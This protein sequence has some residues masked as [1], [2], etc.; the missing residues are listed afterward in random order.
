MTRTATSINDLPPELLRAIVHRAAEH[1]MTK[2]SFVTRL[3]TL[4]A[5]SLVNRTIH[6][7]TQPLLATI[8]HVG[9]TRDRRIFVDKTLGA[10]VNTLVY[11]EFPISVGDWVTT[12]NLRSHF[13]FLQDLRL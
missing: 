6:E 12:A 9:L 8:V 4:S 11:N 10:Q 1:S 3:R 2:E 7:I 13:E 5:L